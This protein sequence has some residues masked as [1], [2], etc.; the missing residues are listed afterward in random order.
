MQRNLEACLEV[1]YNARNMH[2]ADLQPTASVTKEKWGFQYQ[3]Q[4]F[5]YNEE[6]ANNTVVLVEKNQTKMMDHM[7]WV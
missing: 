5:P 4:Y 3:G 1:L 6:N 2:N 7:P